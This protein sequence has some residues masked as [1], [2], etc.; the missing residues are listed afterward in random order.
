MKAGETSRSLWQRP[1]ALLGLLGLIAAAFAVYPIV[2]PS[3]NP[4]LRTLPEAAPEAG[5]QPQKITRDLA[6]GPLAAFVVKPNASPGSRSC[7]FRRKRS[8]EAPVKLARQGGAGQPMGHL[9][10]ALPQGDACLGAPSE[11]ARRSG[12]RGRRHQ[13]RSQGRASLRRLPGRGGGN[14]AQALYRPLDEVAAV[15]CRRS[16]CRRR[17]SIDREGREIGRLLGPAEWD[18]PEAEKLVS[19]AIAETRFHA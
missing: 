10:R 13:H 15:L 2:V 18:S 1:P 12:F 14:G 16:A 11:Q 17:C 4:D 9:V 8:G 6:K 7:L 19:A 3:G 5:G